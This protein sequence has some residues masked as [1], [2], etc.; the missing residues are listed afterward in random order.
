M[1][2]SSDRFLHDITEYSTFSPRRTVFPAMKFRF[3]SDI[4]CKIQKMRNRRARFI[5]YKIRC[6]L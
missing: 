1:A 6:E 3:F 5:V 2:V 4:M